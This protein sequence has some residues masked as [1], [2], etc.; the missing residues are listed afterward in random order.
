MI[1]GA[2]KLFIR[3]EYKNVFRFANI[4]IY[5]LN[6]SI[7]HCSNTQHKPYLFL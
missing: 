1:V 3:G 4:G 5:V 6:I 2:S 7:V